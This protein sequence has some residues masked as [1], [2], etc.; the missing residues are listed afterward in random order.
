MMT[1]CWICLRLH[2]SNVHSSGSANAR[3]F[4]LGCSLSRTTRRTHFN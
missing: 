1:K 2:V 4:L 3:M